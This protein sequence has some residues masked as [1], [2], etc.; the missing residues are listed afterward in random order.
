MIRDDESIARVKLAVRVLLQ[1]RCRS[2][3]PLLPSEV[4]QLRFLGESEEESVMPLEKLAITIIE[5]ERDRMGIPP[6]SEFGFGG[7]N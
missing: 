1:V 4:A 7:R 3:Q 6:Q 2:G 5:R